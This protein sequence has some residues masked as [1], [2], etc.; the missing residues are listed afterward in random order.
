M[1]HAAIQTHCGLRAPPLPQGSP[2][3]CK[4]PPES[5]GGWRLCRGGGESHS[6]WPGEEGAAAVRLPVSRCQPRREGVEMGAVGTGALKYAQ[7]LQGLRLSSSPNARLP[8]GLAP[9]PSPSH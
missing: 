7:L 9:C 5:Q 1:G 4:C 2:C 8:Q 3:L 6:L